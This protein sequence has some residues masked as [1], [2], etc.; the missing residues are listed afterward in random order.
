ML[1]LAGA[2]LTLAGS[3]GAGY[4]IC[5]ERKNR[6]AQL[7]ILGRAFA[8]ISGEIAYSHIPLAEVFLEIGEKIRKPEFWQLGEVFLQIGSRLNDSSG[9]DFAAVW[10]EEMDSFLRGTKLNEKEKER[11]LSFPAAVWYLDGERQQKA[12]LEFAGNMKTAAAQAQVKAAEENRITLAVSL[13]CG[14]LAA[15]LLV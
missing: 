11:V 8:L 5:M 7:Q 15:I 3:F 12:V 4:S 6:T 1:S 13:A 9:Q 2:I 10:Q 14:A